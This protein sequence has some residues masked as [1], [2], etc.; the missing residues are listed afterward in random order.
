MLQLARELQQPRAVTLLEEQTDGIDAEPVGFDVLPPG[1][2]DTE[3]ITV[4]VPVDVEA[5][6]SRTL[7]VHY[8]PR[9]YPGLS[10]DVGGL[11]PGQRVRRAL[12]ALV[13]VLVL[14]T[15][16]YLA[17]RLASRT[18]RI[19]PLNQR[20]V[21]AP[22]RVHGADASLEYLRE[23]LVELLSTRLADDTAARSVDAGAVIRAW[24]RA[25]ITGA[26]DAPRDTVVRLAARLGAE[27]VIVGSVVGTSARAIVS[28]AVVR[29]ASGQ[30]S[31]EVSV[32]GPTD[33]LTSLVDRLAGKL[34]VSQASPDERLA[35]RT[36]PS[37]PALRA[38]LSGLA[39]Y[40][41]GDYAVAAERYARALRFD[42]TF[43]LAALRLSLAA[44]RLN[45]FELERR[46]LDLTW[47]LRDNLSERD[48]AHLLALV[49]PE[50]PAAS[51]R[52]QSLVAWDSAVRLAA[53]R[54]EV[55][56]G[57]AS[58]I[59]QS[60][61]PPLL[62]NDLERAT[63]AL[64][65]ALELDANHAPAQL[66]LTRIAGRAVKVPPVPTAADS[67]ATRQA[68]LQSLAPFLRWRA[69]ALAAD[70]AQLALLGD[71][72]AQLGPVNLRALALTSQFDGLR[73]H[74]GS[75]A[76]RALVTRA[77]N[78][79]QAVD[80]LLAEHGMAVNQGRPAA[81][82]EATRRLQRLT[83]ATRAHLRLRVLDAVFAEG[84]ASAAALAALEL[85]R[86]LRNS[87]SS[88]ADACALAHWQV[89]HRDTAAA[90]RTLAIMRTVPRYEPLPVSTPSSIC[91]DLLEASL[92]VTGE[93][94]D[95][96]TRVARLD[97]LVLN[98][99]A[100]GDAAA[101]AHLVIARLQRGLDQPQRALATLRR[102]PYLTAVWPRYLA[103]SWREEGNLALQLGD[104]A[105]ARSAFL[106]YLA[107]R[108][109][110][111]TNVLPSADSVRAQLVELARTKQ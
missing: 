109:S 106:H 98:T 87:P 95:A 3:F 108:S 80:L 57:Y 51:T 41:Q 25:G 70:S 105:A 45:D 67:G 40:A 31:G 72:L 69:A 48:R 92:A 99:A 17:G 93:R 44:H 78:T 54:A 2:T 7:P 39:P 26:S 76:L 15:F 6:S 101:Y 14:T 47:R 64:E 24:R 32:E 63:A 84:N 55:W 77:A 13:P 86:L 89:A 88:A 83:P 19:D 27:R 46:M 18:P 5:A 4:A 62:G 21:V 81:A 59:V 16:A 60:G 104:T 56:Y 107:L 82:L 37:L 94:A 8:E 52:A 96:R 50:Y 22:F 74:D 42:S 73:L 100:A 33:S 28:A 49:G 68:S 90:R 23:G 38:Y 110:P 29:A 20:V 43:V 111:E 11:L 91:T 30:V 34:L 10:G 61:E 85:G 103:V 75:R 53:N 58:A 1:A 35:D 12:A 102:R 65:R 71:S 66:L 79:E 9:S 36:T 97:S